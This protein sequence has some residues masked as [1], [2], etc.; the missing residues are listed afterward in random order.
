MLDNFTPE[1]IVRWRRQI[2]TPY[3]ALSEREKDS[4]REWADKVLEIVRGAVLM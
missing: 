1:N 3:A 4:D 2:A